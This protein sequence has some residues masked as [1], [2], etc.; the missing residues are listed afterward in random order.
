MEVITP[1]ETKQLKKIKISSTGYGQ[2][3]PRVGS[4]IP[5]PHLKRNRL[6]IGLVILT[7]GRAIL[8]NNFGNFGGLKK[9]PNNK[10]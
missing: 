8:T 10:Y 3:I 2:P 5:Y 6:A 9:S 1:V 7:N 4:I